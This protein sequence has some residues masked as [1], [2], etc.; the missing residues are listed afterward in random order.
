VATTEVH[1]TRALP[2]RVVLDDAS[3]AL[4]P[5]SPADVAIDAEG[6]E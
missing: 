3:V 4:P 6:G 1:L 2:V 5:G